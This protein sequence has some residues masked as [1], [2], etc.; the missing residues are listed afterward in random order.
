MAGKKP[1]SDFTVRLCLGRCGKPFKS[2]SPAV[3]ICPA[4]RKA[5][6]SARANREYRYYGPA[7]TN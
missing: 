4:C 2:P 6:S 3:R 1:P 7:V 5:F